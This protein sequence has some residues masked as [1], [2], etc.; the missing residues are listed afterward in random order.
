MGNTAARY[1]K[2]PAF[3]GYMR[4]AQ[5]RY[6]RKARLEALAAYGG[7]CVCCGE[8]EPV[9][10]AFDHVNDDGAEWRKK[11]TKTAQVASWLRKND[12]PSNFQLLCH[13]CNF[14]KSHGGCPHKLK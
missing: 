11:N 12:W 6:Q 8:V 3:A 13:N 7:A 9:F 5:Q 14:A 10:L 2:D 4:K 1:K